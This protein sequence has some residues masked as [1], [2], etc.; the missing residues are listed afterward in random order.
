VAG[1]SVATIFDLRSMGAIIAQVTRVLTV[2][3]DFPYVRSLQQR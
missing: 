2:A 1:P 3:A